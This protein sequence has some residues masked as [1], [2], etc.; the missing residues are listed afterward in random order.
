MR[1]RRGV[2]WVNGELKFG[3]SYSTGPTWF[4]EE[5]G[6]S[7]LPRLKTRRQTH[8]TATVQRLH[9]GMVGNLDKGGSLWF[10]TIPIRLVCRPSTSI[11]T[12]PASGG[13]RVK[14]GFEHPTGGQTIV[15]SLCGTL[16]VFICYCGWEEERK[17]PVLFLL[18]IIT[19]SPQAKEFMQL[20]YQLPNIAI[21]ICI[22]RSRKSSLYSPLTK[23]TTVSQI[24]TRNPFITFPVTTSFPFTTTT[25]T[26][27]T[28]E[29][30]QHKYP[31]VNNSAPVSS[32][33]LVLVFPPVF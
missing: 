25:T 6:P 19:F 33:Y 27:L 29:P 11:Q 32:K 23:W 22:Q 16:S 12:L 26:P 1:E 3:F 31:D 15:Y 4:Q 8:W 2:K 30:H 28:R 18:Y 20:F 13:M 5:Q 21:Q 7:Q 24:L 17:L 10:R 9:L 14:G